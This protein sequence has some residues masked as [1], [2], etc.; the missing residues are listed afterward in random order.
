MNERQLF[1][2]IGKVD[3]DL[4][5]QA[6]RHH[7]RKH[8]WKGLA[9][10]AACLA[11]AVG[12]GLAGA[13][14]QRSAIS[15]PSAEG[16]A[17]ARYAEKVPDGGIVTSSALAEMT[18]AELLDSA[19][20]AFR[21]TVQSV[22]NIEIDFNGYPNYR[23]IAEVTVKETIRGDVEKGETV[24]ILLP[25]PAGMSQ[26]V[27][28][29]E[30]AAQRQTG[31]EGIFLASLCDDTAYRSEQGATVYWKDL[32]QYYFWDGVRYAFLQTENGLAYDAWAWPSLKQAQ[33]LDDVAHWLR[34]QKS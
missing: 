13:G 7:E 24:T 29:T 15:L 28:D 21:G 34:E 26:W 32:A 27:E 30:I 19:D 16:N 10:A 2:E 11:L 8:I 1:E 3:Q 9:I 17:S 31:V 14:Q 4:V 25:C 20:A 12:V 23:A 33:T 6:E 5:I 18:E 22:Q